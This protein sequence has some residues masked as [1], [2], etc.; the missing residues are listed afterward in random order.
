MKLNRGLMHFTICTRSLLHPRHSAAPSD[1]VNAHNRHYFFCLTWLKSTIT[2]ANLLNRIPR[3]YTFL[4]VHRNHLYNSSP[5]SGGTDFL[6]REPCT[7]FLFH[8]FP[9]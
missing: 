5:K 7:F 1:L 4:S 2:F 8:T 6:T 3:N 9:L